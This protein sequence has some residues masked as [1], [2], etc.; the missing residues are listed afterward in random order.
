MGGVAVILL[1]I[2]SSLLFL[3][4]SFLLV[5]SSSSGRWDMWRSRQHQQLPLDAL[6]NWA[7]QTRAEV[8]WVETQ[9]RNPDN[10]VVHTVVPVLTCVKAHPLMD[11]HGYV[12]KFPYG[13]FSQVERALA[14]WRYRHEQDHQLLDYSSHVGGHPKPYISV[15]I[16]Y[17]LIRCR[18]NDCFGVGPSLRAA[19]AEA[20]AR[21]LRSGHCMIRLG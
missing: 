20:A 15:M 16:C 12:L 8:D 9:Y 4:V 1:L 10:T 6:G 7:G 13:D 3:L 18:I 21:L 17:K 14:D 5:M 11:E 2:S 19:K